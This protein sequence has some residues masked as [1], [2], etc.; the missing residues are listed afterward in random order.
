MTSVEL[1]AIAGTL[2]APGRVFLSADE[3]PTTVDR[4]LASLGLEPGPEARRAYREVLLT[5]SC[6]RDSVSAVALAE[7]A[8]GQATSDGTGFPRVLA[9]HGLPWG[10]RLDQALSH[11]AECPGETETKGLA[12]LPLRLAR[13]RRLGAQFARWRAVFVIGEDRPSRA[14]L[15]ANAQAA[16]RFAAVCQE[17]GIVPVV[18]VRFLRAG[19]HSLERSAA[20]GE[21]VL[22]AVVTELVAQRVDLSG[23]VLGPSMILPGTAAPSLA[24]SEEVARATRHCLLQQVPDLV[25]AVVLSTTGQSASAAAAHLDALVSQGAF[26]WPLALSSGPTLQEAVLRAWCGRPDGIPAAH[27]LLAHRLRCHQA[28]ARADWSPEME[29]SLLPQLA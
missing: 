5:A 27:Q 28:A 18:S 16:A 22:A 17:E 11:L 1:A 13:A 12:D 24:T 10:V 19:H 7:E 21:A 6:L 4:R 14:A 15:A 8:L 2:A 9:G 29:H 25:G 23:V 3:R 20:G 26:P